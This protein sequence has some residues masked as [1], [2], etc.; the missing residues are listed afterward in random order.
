M[1]GVG[2]CAVMDRNVLVQVAE[3][4]R[5]MSQRECTEFNGT[6]VVKMPINMVV[7]H[8]VSCISKKEED[9]EQKL[10]LLRKVAANTPS[11]GLDRVSDVEWRIVVPLLTQYGEIGKGLTERIALMDV[12]EPD[13]E[14]RKAFMMVKR[15]HGSGDDREV[16]KLFT[17]WLQD[18]HAQMAC[19]AYLAAPSALS[20]AMKRRRKLCSVVGTLGLQIRSEVDEAIDT[21]LSRL[22]NVVEEFARVLGRRYEDESREALLALKRIVLVHPFIMARR[23]E[24]L[25]AVCRTVLYGL[26][27]KEGKYGKGALR[28]ME[29]VVVVVGLL[30]GNCLREESVVGL[31]EEMLHF[32]VEENRGENGVPEMF[33]DLTIAVFRLVAKIEKEK[34]ADLVEKVRRGRGTVKRITETADN[35]FG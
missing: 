17:S 32:L 19:A 20:D 10:E 22:L 25:Q 11:E 23:M 26:S 16:L 34:V 27:E 6:G 1:A 35:L 30:P 14:V 29:I 3:D 31:C 21:A 13:D 33:A 7:E 28:V 8:V 15:I 12:A 9:Y 2:N 5:M 4:L 18:G 24:C